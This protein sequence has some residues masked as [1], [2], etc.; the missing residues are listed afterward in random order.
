MIQNRVEIVPEAPVVRYK[1]PGDEII[2]VLEGML[3]DA[4]D[5]RLPQT[6]DSD[7]ALI[8]PAEKKGTPFL[9]VV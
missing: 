9:V 5:G 1:S 6:S 8:V 4:T 7:E 3:D 2:Y